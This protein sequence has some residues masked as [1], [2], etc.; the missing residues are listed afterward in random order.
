MPNL[1]VAHGH[2]E[3]GDADAEAEL[4]EFVFVIVGGVVEMLG[5]R[6]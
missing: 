6:D 4:L 5:V 3:V 1:F 2:F